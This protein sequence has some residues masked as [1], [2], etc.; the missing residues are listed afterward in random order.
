M[1]SRPE[2]SRLSKTADEPR[3]RSVPQVYR[4]YISNN[5]ERVVRKKKIRKGKKELETR[6][7]ITWS[8]IEMS[9]SLVVLAIFCTLQTTLC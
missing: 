3:I 9:C 8:V 5:I 2:A 1:K 6:E 4:V 7:T